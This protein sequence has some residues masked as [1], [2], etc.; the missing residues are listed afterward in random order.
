MAISL[1]EQAD[2]LLDS[3]VLFMWSFSTLY[4]FPPDN[5]TYFLQTQHI[6]HQ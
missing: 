1:V 5:S 2:A 6:F 3:G 4:K